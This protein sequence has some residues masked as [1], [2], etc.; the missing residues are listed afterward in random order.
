MSR[1]QLL[2]VLDLPI[3]L[4]MLS[5][6]RYDHDLFVSCLESCGD[7]NTLGSVNLVASKHPDLNASLS[8]YINC[9]QHVL[10]ELIFDASHSKEVHLKLEAHDCLG[11]LL[12]SVD[13]G[14]S[15][16]LHASCKVIVKRLW[17]QFL[18]NDESS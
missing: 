6:S 1:G 8:Q 16:L 18:C 14:G 13:H 3:D 11:N 10:L 12:F 2:I 7:G 5:L 17:N 4:V 9:L 15:C